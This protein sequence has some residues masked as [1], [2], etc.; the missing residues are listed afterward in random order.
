MEEAI[1][2]GCDVRSLDELDHRPNVCLSGQALSRCQL[3][4]RHL[5]CAARRAIAVRC[6]RDSREARA[7]PPLSPPKRPSSTAAAFFFGLAGAGFFAV[8]LG[9]HPTS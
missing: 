1:K 2:E 3:V 5:V 8:K 7:G 9:S 4:L 6:S